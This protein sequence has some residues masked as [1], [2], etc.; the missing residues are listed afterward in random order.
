MM[1]KD[2]NWHL[3]FIKAKNIIFG[4]AKKK[5][6]RNNLRECFPLLE[7][8]HLILLILE[9]EMQQRQNYLLL[10]Q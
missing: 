7:S 4:D 10:K 9:L 5:Y 2:A 1:A 3:L 6:F 8:N